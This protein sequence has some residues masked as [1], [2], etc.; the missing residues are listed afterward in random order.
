[1]APIEER[2][3][4][5]C[6]RWFRYIQPKTKDTQFR[7]EII[8]RTGNRKR[9]NKTKSDLEETIEKIFEVLKNHQ[10]KLALDRR[11]WKITNYVSSYP[12]LLV[13]FLPFSPLFLSF[14][15]FYHFSISFLFGLLLSH[16][17]F[18][19]FYLYLFLFLFF[20]SYR[21]HL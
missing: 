7:S 9:Q 6:L 15:F 5:D 21:F 18:L 20:D 17:L 12:F 8:S 3:M 4:Q 14:N 13:L 19:L 10:E 16:L 11:E 1:V 2:F